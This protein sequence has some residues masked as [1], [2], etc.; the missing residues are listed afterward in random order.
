MANSGQYS[1]ERKISNQYDPEQEEYIRKWIEDVIGES[2]PN[3]K[4]SV[5]LKDGVILCNLINK[6]SPGSITKINNTKMPFKQMENIAKFIE[7]TNKYGV[8]SRDL[9]QTVDLYEARNMIQVLRSLEALGRQAQKLGY[10]GPTIGA[11]MATENR[12]S[13]TEEQ[14]KQSDAVISL[15]YG[16]NKGANQSGMRFPSA[17]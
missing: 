17:A 15:Q 11:K 14:L 9:F 3:G 7:A 12:R 1:R 10:D 5:V 6:L 4:F 16:T 2:L 8:P 13:F